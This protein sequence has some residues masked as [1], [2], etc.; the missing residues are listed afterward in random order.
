MLGADVGGALSY[1]APLNSEPLYRGMEKGLQRHKWQGRR[2]AA[3]N[4]PRIDQSAC[5]E[6]AVS[7]W[8]DPE[9]LKLSPNCPH[10]RRRP[11]KAGRLTGHRRGQK[12]SDTVAIPLSTL[13]NRR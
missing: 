7:H 13:T 11:P 10:P 3:G 9:P 1:V 8:V 6:L 5:F 4:S 2:L 12:Y